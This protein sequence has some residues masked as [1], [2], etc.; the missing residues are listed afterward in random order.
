MSRGAI[1]AAV[2]T[3]DRNQPIERVTLVEKVYADVFSRQRFVLQ[4]II[5]FGAV[6]VTLTLAILR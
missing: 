1:K 4:L 6:A 5:A 2:W 3:I